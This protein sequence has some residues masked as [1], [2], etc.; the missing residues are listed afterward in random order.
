MAMDPFGGIC[1]PAW[2]IAH[3]ST[4]LDYSNPSYGYYPW[5]VSTLAR[6]DILYMCELLIQNILELAKRCYKE[7]SLF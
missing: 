4:L 2:V 1:Y 7:P 3:A 5:T 6:Y